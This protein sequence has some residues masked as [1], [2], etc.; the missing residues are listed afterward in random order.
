MRSGSVAGVRGM[1]T[2]PE[3]MH[4]ETSSPLTQGAT[5]LV[6]LSEEATPTEEGSELAWTITGLDQGVFNQD[7]RGRWTN[8][9]TGLVLGEEEAAKQ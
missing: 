2:I 9:L 3:S 6:F 1:K 8:T 4:V 5:Y 7:S